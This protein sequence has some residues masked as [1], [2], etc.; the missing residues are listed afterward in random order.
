[1]ARPVTLFTGQW[2]DLPIEEM[3]RMTAEFGYDGIEL[4]CWGDHFEVDKA[5]AEDDYCDKRRK[6]LDDLGLQ[7]HAI[8]THLDT[9][10][11]ALVLHVVGGFHVENFTG[12]PEQVQHYR[13]DTR[14]LVVSMGN[15]ADFRIFDPDEH[16]GLGDFVILTDKSLDLEYA[17]YCTEGE[18]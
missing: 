15:V 11:G 8:S 1:M 14:S 16:T 7:C 6:L 10:P 2:A 18:G 12:I 4:A 3:A 13:P 5:L 9:T 17:R